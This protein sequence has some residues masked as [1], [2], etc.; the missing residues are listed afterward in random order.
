MSAQNGSDSRYKVGPRPLWV[1]RV[2]VPRDVT[3]YSANMASRWV[4]VKAKNAIAGGK[5]DFCGISCSATVIR[6]LGKHMHHDAGI[7]LGG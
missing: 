4:M 3:S 7:T 2:A 6:D 5:K 1:V